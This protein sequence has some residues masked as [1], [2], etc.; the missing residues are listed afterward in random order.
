MTTMSMSGAETTTTVSGH[1]IGIQAFIPV[2]KDDLEMQ[3]KVPSL[4]LQMKDGTPEEHSAA[5]AELLSL[6]YQ[7]DVRSQHINKR[8]PVSEAQ[9]MLAKNEPEPETKAEKKPKKK[10]EAADDDD[11][12]EE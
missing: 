6:A 3:V 2:G 12:A 7:P 4:L 5:L 8:F 1:A 9:A 10:N 11:N